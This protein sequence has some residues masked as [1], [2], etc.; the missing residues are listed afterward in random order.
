MYLHIGENYVLKTDAVIGIFD[1]DTATVN[2]AT[3]DY[4]N[5]AEKEKR[6]VYTSYDLPKS[7][8]VTE[9]KI[10]VSPLNTA[11]LLKRTRQE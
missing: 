9:E 5:K 6:I 2:K 7:F 11:T 10:Y 3:R 1:M 8:I 4:L